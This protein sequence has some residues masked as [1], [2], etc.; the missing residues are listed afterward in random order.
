M[1]LTVFVVFDSLK[2]HTLQYL[3]VSSWHS[4]FISRVF[5]V[6]YNTNLV[7]FGLLKERVKEMSGQKKIFL[8]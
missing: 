5:K 1:V 8:Q 4:L 7:A 2:F 6:L 3:F